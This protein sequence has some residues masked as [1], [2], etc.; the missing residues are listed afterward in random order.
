MTD[1]TTQPK[2]FSRAARDTIR[3]MR[4]HQWLKNFLLFVP[5]VTSHRIWD[6][7]VF[8]MVF[9]AFFSFSVCASAGYLINDLLDVKS[10]RMHPEKKLRPFASGALSARFGVAVAVLLFL[11]GAGFGRIVSDTYLLCLCGY[12]VL[13][14]AYSLILKTVLLLDIFLLA[15]FY[16]LRI[17]LGGEAAH[18]QVSFWLAAFST[19]FFFSLAVLK[20]FTEVQLLTTAEGRSTRRRDYQTQDMP[21]LSMWGVASGCASVVVLALYI[22]SEEVTKLYR[23]PAYLWPVCLAFLFWLN[24]VWMLANRRQL[25][26]DPIIFAVKDPQ[27]YLVAAFV[28]GAVWLAI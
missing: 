27:S 26:Y 16:T 18:V 13:T 21:M 7:E 9:L 17:F 8:R 3:G 24:R 5:A 23:H 6:F 22:N 15:F 14:V 12:L 2:T 1:P 25:T 10:D 11:T 28:T 4:V 19:F 20:R